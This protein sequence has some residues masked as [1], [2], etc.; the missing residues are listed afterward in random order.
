M[1][2]IYKLTAFNLKGYFIEEAFYTSKTKA[3]S[4]RS[5]LIAYLIDN[6]KLSSKIDTIT[7]DTVIIGDKYNVTLCEHNIKTTIS[8]Y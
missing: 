5:S 2:K 4:S 3:E 8:K 7:S 6:H 1:R